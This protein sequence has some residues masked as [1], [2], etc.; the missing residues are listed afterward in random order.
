[1]IIQ[2]SQDNYRKNDRKLIE[3]ENFFV[4]ST[5]SNLNNDKEN[6]VSDLKRSWKDISFGKENIEEEKLCL[7][8]QKKQKITQEISLN[9]SII[10]QM[11]FNLFRFNEHPE[12][13]NFYRK[14]Q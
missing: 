13:Q 3:L 12:K 7:A 9:Y 8:V 14:Y 11:I 6:I 4:P 5:Q 10:N 1:M 2:N